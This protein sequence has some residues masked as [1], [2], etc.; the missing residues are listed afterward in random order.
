MRWL[1]KDDTVRD[2]TYWDLKALSNR[3]ANV[4]RTL[5]IGKGERV[6]VL[7]GRLPELY[8]AALGTFKNTSVFC[9]LFAAF[10]PEPIYQR[11]TRG[12]GAMLVTTARQYREKVAT[13]RDRLPLLRY[14]LLVDV[15]EDLEASVLSLPRLMQAAL[16]EF[17]IPPT[18]PEDMA[19]IHFT[20]GTTGMPKGA[21]HVHEAALVHYAPG[22]T[23]SISTH[24]T[25][26]G[27]RP[28][29]AGS[30]ASRTD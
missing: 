29:P 26:S 10:G 20:S 9:P 22:S 18:D 2:F 17:T 12:D 21:V 13:N 3:F 5:G 14:V 23:C 15:D 25:F 30:P 4:L 1:G 6:F 28:T 16:E 11:L 19:I 27:A 7:T 8:I 24:R